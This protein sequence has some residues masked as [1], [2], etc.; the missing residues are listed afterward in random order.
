MSV[1]LF[2][3]R[4][5][6]S[7]RGPRPFVW[8]LAEC[9]ELL[10]PYRRPPACQSAEVLWAVDEREAV[11]RVDAGYTAKARLC[12]RCCRQL[13]RRMRAEAGVLP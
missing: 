5:P 10:R 9:A 6:R 3:R 2:R 8:H 4:M 1:R 13:P 12:H 7:G 11:V